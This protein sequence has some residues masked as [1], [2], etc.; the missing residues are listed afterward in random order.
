M[1]HLVEVRE[2]NCPAVPSGNKR[3]Y[4]VQTVLVVYFTINDLTKVKDFLNSNCYLGTFLLSFHPTTE[5][6]IRHGANP[7]SPSLYDTRL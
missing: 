6:A 3:I 5:T 2:F 7:T 4:R 1:L